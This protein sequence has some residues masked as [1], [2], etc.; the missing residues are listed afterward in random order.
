MTVHS[1]QAEA[2]HGRP[3]RRVADL[4][5]VREVLGAVMAADLASVCVAGVVTGHEQG[6]FTVALL[7]DHFGLPGDSDWTRAPGFRDKYLQK[8]A[9]PGE[10][11]RA[12]AL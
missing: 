2:L 8:T 11:A 10:V 12:P 7:R 4:E 5:N 3:F 9:L 6:V 1:H